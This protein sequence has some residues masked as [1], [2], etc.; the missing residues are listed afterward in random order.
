VSVPVLISVC[1]VFPDRTPRWVADTC[2][3]NRIPGAIRIGKKWMIR[4]EDVERLVAGSGARGAPTVA[5]AEAELR[6]RGVF[7]GGK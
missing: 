2:R 3:K 6:A 1:S 7:G 5:D 4:P